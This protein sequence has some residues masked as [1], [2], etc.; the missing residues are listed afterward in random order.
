MKIAE[1]LDLLPS[2][3]FVEFRGDSDTEFEGLTVRFTGRV[4]KNRFCLMLTRSWESE[5]KVK[6]YFSPDVS[7]A[8]HIA[9][10]R[11]RGAAG[12]ILPREYMDDPA[13]DGCNVVFVDDTTDFVFESVGAIRC[14]E[15]AGRITAVTGSAG[16]S[17]TKMM[18]THALQELVPREE[19]YSPANDQNIEVTVLGH[20]SVNHK[21]P[22]S[23]LEV[24]GSA[25]QRFR[26]RSFSVSADVSI[27]TSISEAHLDY[28]KNTKTVAEVKSDLFLSPPPAGTA[29]V[30]LDAMHSD[31]LVRRAIQDG[32]QLVTYGEAPEATI[33]LRDYDIITGTVIAEFGEERMEY[34]VGA[35]GKHMALNSLAVIATLRAH[36]FREWRKAVESLSTFQALSGRGEVVN[37]RLEKGTVM[38]IDEAYNANPASM[39]ATIKSFDEM[40]PRNS[41]RKIAVLGDILE[42]GPDSAQIHLE[43][44]KHIKE[45]GFDQVHFVGE[46]MLKVSEAMT[47]GGFA[48]R[49]WTDLDLLTNELRLE[50]RDNDAILLKSSKG[51]GLHKVVS[52]LRSDV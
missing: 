20:M 31:I 28:M 51:T 10:A 50:L 47:G 44:V 17:T 9:V 6:K 43:L 22:H 15:H 4:V 1:L 3:T 33:R 21:Y 24:A 35:R 37:I 45:A 36:G 11:K 12:F 34:V 32:R 8:Q 14:S 40:Q 46:N 18:I 49:H 7:F 29:I 52:A 25:L 2:G 48:V 38:M 16:K 27:V 41:G 13:V 26:R 23:V 30:N 39:R 5:S 19:I 42:L